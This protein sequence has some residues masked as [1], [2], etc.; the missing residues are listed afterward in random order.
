MYA[1]RSYYERHVVVHPAEGF[2]VGREQGMQRRPL[3]GQQ[4][5]QRVEESRHHS[6]L[7]GSA[8]DVEFLAH[9]ILQRA[10]EAESLFQGAALQLTGLDQEFAAYRHRHFGGGGATWFFE[11]RNTSLTASTRNNFV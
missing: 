11:I 5:E 3:Q 8:L 2:A 10:H 1:I 7:S 4:P 9:Q 6:L